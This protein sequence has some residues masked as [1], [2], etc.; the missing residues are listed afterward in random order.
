[1]RQKPGLGAGGLTTTG[2]GEDR[3]KRR[4]EK[5]VYLLYISVNDGTL[6][7]AVSSST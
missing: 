1:M 2:G 7:L 5:Q 6:L 4:R 3:S